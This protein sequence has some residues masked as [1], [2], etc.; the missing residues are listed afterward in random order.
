MRLPKRLQGD[1][2]GV[3]TALELAQ[4]LQHRSKTDNHRSLVI[5]EV[6]G[7]NDGEISLEE[8]DI[9]KIE[10][11]TIEKVSASS[12]YITSVKKIS[13][14]C[15]YHVSDNFRGF[16]ISDC[17]LFKDSYLYFKDSSERV[18]IC[19]SGSSLCSVVF[20]IKGDPL[21][22][23]YNSHLK[24]CTLPEPTANGLMRI[25]A[26][27]LLYCKGIEYAQ[28]SWN[29]HGERGRILTGVL[30]D[31]G[32]VKDIAFTCGCFTGSL[33]QLEK[34]IKVDRVATPR[35]TRTR[36]MAMNA[37]VSML[38]PTRMK[39]VKKAQPKKKTTKNV[40]HRNTTAKASRR[41]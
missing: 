30:Y 28:V 41:V 3:I 33:K 22:R 16:S 39:I 38:L 21:C 23:I 4:V 26:S 10:D 15:I 20:H 27:T 32:S 29:G 18:D 11:V 12:I 2:L 34:Y 19:M 35:I 13:Y 37:I 5:Q 9:D 24:Y 17:Q 6:K 1:C 36:R 8:D 25:E 7:D 31:K 14:L 40:N